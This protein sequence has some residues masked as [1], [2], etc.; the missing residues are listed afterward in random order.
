MEQPLWQTWVKHRARRFKRSITAT[1]YGF[2]AKQFDGFKICSHGKKVHTKMNQI[3]VKIKFLNC[4]GGLA[5]NRTIKISRNTDELGF[6]FSKV[7]RALR[8]EPAAF[9]TAGCSTP[10]LGG[11]EKNGTTVINPTGWQNMA[12]WATP[13]MGG[14]GST[15]L[16]GR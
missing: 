14:P 6:N 10:L 9:W 4:W 5:H 11:R 1:L 13:K 2:L 16:G 8:V 7:I 15:L 12:E 3:R